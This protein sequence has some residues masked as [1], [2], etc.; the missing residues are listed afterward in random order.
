MVTYSVLEPPDASADRM[1][2]AEELV[3]IRDGFS[4]YAAAL[5]PVWMLVKRMWLELAIYMGAAGLIAW[6]AS[7]AGQI[8][9]GN[10]ILLAAQIIFGFES[11]TLHCASLE[12]RGWR[13]VG[14]VTGRNREDCE[15]RFLEVWLPTRTEIPPPAAGSAPVASAPPSWTR[16]AFTQAKD[17]ILRGPNAAAAADSKA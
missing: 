15:R 16:R 11:G 8:E 17:A 9:L 10:A 12:R 1:E 2:S 3:F 6:A 4:F 7:A 5:P 13:H 14:T